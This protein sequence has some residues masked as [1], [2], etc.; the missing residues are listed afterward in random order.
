MPIQFYCPSCH[1]PIEVDDEAANQMVLCP[2]CNATNRAPASSNY[3]LYPATAVAS[4][5]AA[6]PPQPS[7]IEYAPKASTHRPARVGWAA[8]AF[9]IASFIC[10]GVYIGVIAN[11]LP[12]FGPN[13][14]LAAMQKET[15]KLHQEKPWLLAV[16]LIMIISPF[17]SLALGIV[18]LAMRE[19]PGWPAILALCLSGAC[20]L[21][22]C[23]SIVMTF[24]FMP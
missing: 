14:D 17:A 23:G 7:A 4:A 5:P 19:K 12:V 11:E 15:I 1:R 18:A 16:N 9:A 3:E 10:A 8:L 13:P 22:F 21:G 24:M 2:F 20:T 6:V